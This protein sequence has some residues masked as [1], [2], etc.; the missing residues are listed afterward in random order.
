MIVVR[1]ATLVALVLWLGAMTAARFGELLRRVDLVAYSCGAVIIVGLFVMK[2]IGPPPHSFA[3]RAGI[4]VLMV[5]I[6]I[7]AAS[8]RMAGATDA[9]LA[10]NIVLGLVLLT[11]YARE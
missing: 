3:A 7:G 8:A 6:A 2:F 9:L 4:A 10:V 11:W 5:A 1:F